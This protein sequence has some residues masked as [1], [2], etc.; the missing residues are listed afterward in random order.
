M[1]VE[2]GLGPGGGERGHRETNRESVKY[3]PMRNIQMVYGHGKMK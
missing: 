1:L 3:N 2:N